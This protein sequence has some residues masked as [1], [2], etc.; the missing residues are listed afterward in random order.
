MMI[1]GA[2]KSPLDFRCLKKWQRTTGDAAFRRPQFANP[3]K[4]QRKVL[5]TKTFRANPSFSAGL[6]SRADFAG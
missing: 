3:A 4:S 1:T 5:A 2:G 6:A